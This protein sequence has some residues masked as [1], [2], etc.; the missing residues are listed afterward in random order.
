MVGVL[1]NIAE[2]V[3]SGEVK[4]AGVIGLG[5]M[6]APIARHLRKAGF[7]VRGYDV[8]EA[9]LAAVRQDDIAIDD[10]PLSL[11]SRSDLVIVLP[12]FERQV[13]NAL[14]SSKGVVAG[15]RPGTIVA[16][17]ATIAPSGMRSIAKRLG[18]YG[19]IALDI[20]LC[21]GDRAAAA[22]KLLITGG[23]DREAFERC[24]R[25][26]STFADSIHHLGE[27]G[28]GQVGK[29]INNLILWACICANH[30]GFALGEAIGVD[31]EA[32]RT[33]LLESSAANWAMETRASDTP[34]PWAEKDMMIVLDEADH[35]HLAMPLSGVV[36]EVVK[37][38]K[39]AR[40]E[41][42]LPRALD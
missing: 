25:A 30:E 11:A 42:V 20:P 9:A 26:F 31:R 10:S 24:R 33:M 3:V 17:G 7:E 21:R 18:E 40:G 32:M 29:M 19:L 6:G 28:A 34:I 2:D 16:I 22:G 13:E 41:F 23:G 27:A 8:S 14:F 4:S 12:A 1:S 37:G 39:I 36:K 38:I 35:A 5:K 15:A